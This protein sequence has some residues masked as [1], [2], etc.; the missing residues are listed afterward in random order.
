M[1]FYIICIDVFVEISVF[2]FYIV[3]M[4]YYIEE[5][6]SNVLVFVEVLFIYGFNLLLWKYFKG[7]NVDFN[8]EDNFIFI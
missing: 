5:F 6:L 4:K 2:E 7:V 3:E 1:E 8:L